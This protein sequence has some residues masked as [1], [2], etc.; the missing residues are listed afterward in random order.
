[1][2]IVL[3]DDQASLYAVVD[4]TIIHA[5]RVNA[6]DQCIHMKEL[7]EQLGIA[8]PY[9]HRMFKL[10]KVRIEYLIHLQN[11]LGLEFITQADIDYGLELIKQAAAKR[12]V[13]H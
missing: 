5:V 2:E 4:D 6:V 10:G 11:I 13:L 9:L 12:Y 8:R 7:A 1:M 3:G